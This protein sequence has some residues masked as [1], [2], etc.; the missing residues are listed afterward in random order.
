MDTGTGMTYGPQDFPELKRLRRP[1]GA[2]EDWLEQDAAFGVLL[3]DGRLVIRYCNQWLRRRKRPAGAISPVR[4]SLPP[5]PNYG[6][7]AWNTITG[8]P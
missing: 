7:A 6:N 8:R 5:S 2:I 1:V 4:P 3:T